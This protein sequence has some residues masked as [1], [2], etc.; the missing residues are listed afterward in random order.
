MK[1]LKIACTGATTIPYKELIQFQGELKNLSHDDY[2]KLRG[3]IEN[4]GFGFPIVVWKADDGK[5]YIIDGHQRL[6]VIMKMAEDGWKIPPLPVS[7]SSNDDTRQAKA[8]LLAGASHFGRIQ[9]QGLYE[10]SVEANLDYEQIAA[11]V[12]TPEINL[13]RFRVEFFDDINQSIEA[14]LSSIEGSKEL[15]SDMFDNFDHQCP[16][17]GFE[18]NG[19]S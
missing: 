4:E 14:S 9:D 13:D 17:C 6:R 11:I 15:T 3:L 2:L 7:F 8:R 19:K 16:K 18:F 1:V 12:S 10:Y 5:N